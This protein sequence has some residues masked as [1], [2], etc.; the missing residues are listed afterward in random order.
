M[1]LKLLATL[2]IIVLHLQSSDAHWRLPHWPSNPSPNPV[3]ANQ[4][5]LVSR[6]C[7]VVP[8]KPGGMPSV[9]SLLPPEEELS[10]QKHRRRRHHRGHR[11]HALRP[12]R[13]MRGRGECCRWMKELDSLCACGLLVHLPIFLLRPVHSYTVVVDKSCIVTFRCG[14]TV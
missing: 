4:F 1:S 11:V 13:P 9:P 5:A 7:S 3:C 2:L 8:I 6:A 14:P 10:L 12:G